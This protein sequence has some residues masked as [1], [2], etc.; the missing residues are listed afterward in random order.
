MG[1]E[2]HG[3]IDEAKDLEL[4]A[5]PSD[6]VQSAA[7]NAIATQGVLEKVHFHAGP[8]A[9]RQSFGER[10]RYLA[11]FKEK[12]LERYGAL[13][14]TDRLEQGRE[15]LIAIFQRRHFVTFEQRWS[16]QISHHSDEDLVSDCVV[17]DDFVMDLL[18]CREKIA[19]DK[20][21]CRSANGGG[22]EGDRPP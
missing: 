9:F 20:E 12:V 14:G 5:G 15:N 8:S 6:Q 10:I 7:M 1:A 19:G 17:S 21:R 4:D 2:I 18:L 13:R 3:D 16:E 11:L 22:A